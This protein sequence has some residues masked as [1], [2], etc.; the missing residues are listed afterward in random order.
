MSDERLHELKRRLDELATEF[1]DV[2]A[3]EEQTAPLL[4]GVVLVTGW[5]DPVDPDDEV[6]VRATMSETTSELVRIG[7]LSF[8]AARA[9]E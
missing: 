3:H 7:L 5:G 1:T 4:T 8:A 6:W 2:L 9:L